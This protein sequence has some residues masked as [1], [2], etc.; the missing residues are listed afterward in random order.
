M[1]IVCISRGSQSQG[2]KFAKILAEKLGYE[3]LSREELLEEATKRRIPVGKLETS[4]IK[5]HIFTEKLAHELEHYKALATSLLCEK[6]LKG[7]VVYHGRTGHLL[8]PGINHILKIRAISEIENRVEYVMEKLQLPWNKAKRYLEQ[9][10]EDRRR[11]VKTFYNIDWDVCTLYDII[12]NL[13][14]TNINNAASVICNMAQLPEFQATPASTNR[15]KDLY[16]AS[17]SK[18]ALFSDRRTSHL[19]IG[20]KANNGILNV[21]YPH[22]L[23]DK[24]EIINE[25]LRDVEGAR[26][27]VYTKAQ[28]NILWIQ[29][30]FGVSD[31][32]YKRVLSL[33]NNWDAAVELLKLVPGEHIEGESEKQKKDNVDTEF[34]RESG[35][36]EEGEDSEPDSFQDLSTLYEKLIRDGRAG[37]EKAVALSQK[38]LLNS[39]DRTA[40]YRLIIFDNAFL[41]KGE[42]TRKR[43]LQ[44]WSNALMD[45]LKTPVVNMNELEFKYR[46]GPR[47]FV[48]MFIYMALTAVIAFALFK[49]SPQVI[50]F[51]SKEGT[52]SRIIAMLCV[53]AFVPLFAQIY[54][55]FAGLL[56]KLFKFD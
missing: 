24:I 44:E 2:E 27:I 39:I 55:S 6:A 15:L 4:I 53:L 19:G 29:E 28:T 10:D 41:S 49:F 47:Q 16:L 34:W 45:S 8:L 30:E 5:P 23:A 36:I 50:E 52:S 43:S 22:Q 46:F 32:A 18:L 42:A 51:L 38:A 7:S 14:Y 35:I 56:L 20:I 48:Q 13:S 1:Q 37:G 11:W 12:I 9:V 26:E 21:N 17:R 33:A 31:D 40:D 25:I 54:G 3:C